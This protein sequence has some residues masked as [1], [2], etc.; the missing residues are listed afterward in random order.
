LTFSDFG[1]KFKRNFGERKF[2]DEKSLKQKF[3]R[4]KLRNFEKKNF[5]SRTK[6]I[7]K[8]ILHPKTKNAYRIKNCIKIKRKKVWVKIL[9]GKKNLIYQKK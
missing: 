5:T 9:V 2:F 7:S 8:K 6:K 3:E 1:K 4:Q